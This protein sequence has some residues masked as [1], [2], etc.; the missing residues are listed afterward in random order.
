MRFPFVWTFQ[1]SVFWSR[2]Y[3]NCWCGFQLVLQ[4]SSKASISWTHLACLSTRWATRF[5]VVWLYPLCSFWVGTNGT[6]ARLQWPFPSDVWAGDRKMRLCDHATRFESSRQPERVRCGLNTSTVG[7]RWLRGP[8]NCQQSTTSGRLSCEFLV[9]RRLVEQVWQS[10]KSRRGLGTGKWVFRAVRSVVKAHPTGLRF[11]F[12]SWC[13]LVGIRRFHHQPSWS[14]RRLT[15]T[16][17]YECRPCDLG[18]RLG[19]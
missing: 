13:I 18:C 11:V 19:R 6:C 10:P 1:C 9:L 17:M 14:T 12:W 5:Q 7:S 4:F 2:W 16:L 15:R 3:Y 8:H